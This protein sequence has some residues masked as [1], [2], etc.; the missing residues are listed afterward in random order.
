MKIENEIVVHVIW[1]HVLCILLFEIRVRYVRP[2]VW[3]FEMFYN[4]YNDVHTDTYTYIS[5]TY[6]LRTVPILW[7][8]S[9]MMMMII[10][11]IILSTYFLLPFSHFNIPHFPVFHFYGV[12]RTRR[13]YEFVL[14]KRTF[15][16]RTYCHQV[17]SICLWWGIRNKRA[18]II[19]STAVFATPVYIN[20]N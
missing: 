10:S 12:T 17:P 6:A 18:A 1:K 20:K 4:L 19:T 2:R 14:K 7:P 11:I 13:R 9:F 5:R 8:L 15:V 16:C 3:T